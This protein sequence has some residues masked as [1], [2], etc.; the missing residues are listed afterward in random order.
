M[1]GPALVVVIAAVLL[2]GILY[3]RLAFRESRLIQTVEDFLPLKRY[4]SSRSVGATVVAAGMSMA[5]VMVALINLAPFI[6]SALF[7][8][9]A[10]YAAGFVLLSF[11]TKRILDANPRNLVLQSY[12]SEAY[13]SGVLGFVATGF[14]VV[15]YLSIFAMELLVGTSILAPVL[16]SW[17]LAFATIY[18]G[19][20]LIYSALSGYRGVVATDRWQ[21]FF[22]ILAVASLVAFV[23]WNYLTYGV[24]A[25][26]RS[27][28]VHSLFSWK[29]SWAFVIGVTVMNI[30]G[31]L[32][33]TGTW[34]RICSAESPKAARAGIRSAVILFV[35]IWCALIVVGCLHPTLRLL[36]G[37]WDATTTPL[38]TGIIDS[39]AGSGNPILLALLFLLVLGL[40][41][42][43]I[44]T[45]DSLLLAAG[46]AALT[47]FRGTRWMND[48]T[49]AL[50]LRRSRLWII[51]LGVGSFIVFLVFHLLSFNVVQL[52]FAIYGAQLALW[53]TTIATLIIRNPNDLRHLRTYAIASI[54]FGFLAA[55]GCAIWGQSTA[56]ANLQFYAPAVGLTTAILAMVPGVFFAVLRRRA[57]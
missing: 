39:L 45:A 22:I 49:P 4:L 31:P 11:L 33:D 9:I 44:S 26:F 51:A 47:G 43:M 12:L 38:M 7:I 19:F 2:P 40:F 6:G 20:L 50:A 52:V 27:P 48:A 35:F 53:P 36:D 32:S 56:S 1:S 29:G 3:L 41:S 57:Q 37:S 54:A 14:T 23:L 55:W 21:L 10:T 18:L 16:G 30:P 8:T 34:Q 17:T 24:S 5:T 25:S 28:A 46:Q 15:G 13:G 42:A